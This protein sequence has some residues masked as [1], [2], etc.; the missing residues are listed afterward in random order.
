MAQS[1]K[2]QNN[3]K[4]PQDCLRLYFML[5]PKQRY[6]RKKNISEKKELIYITPI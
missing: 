3:N 1:K 4:K 6:D 5:K 2:K